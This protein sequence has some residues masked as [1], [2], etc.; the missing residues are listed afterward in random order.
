MAASVGAIVANI[1]YAQP[2]LPDIARAFGLSAT[3]IGI[4]AMLNPAGAGLGNC[5][6][7]LWAISASDAG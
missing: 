4:F 2:L 6:S 7:F 3:G 5:C 1:Y